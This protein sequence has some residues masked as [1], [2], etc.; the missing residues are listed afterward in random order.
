M[1]LGSRN[2]G[3]PGA[4]KQ[5]CHP[6]FQVADHEKARF[7]K[8]GAGHGDAAFTASTLKQWTSLNSRSAL[9]T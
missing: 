8:G 6:S 2:D 4:P 9:F 7:K 5:P 3:T 1:Y